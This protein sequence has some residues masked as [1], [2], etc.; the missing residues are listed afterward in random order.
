MDL[1]KLNLHE[2]KISIQPSVNEIEIAID[3]YVAHL[4]ERWEIPLVKVDEKDLVYST[5]SS[6]LGTDYCI[7][8]MLEHA[9]MHPIRHEFQ[10]RQLLK[11]SWTTSKISKTFYLFLHLIL[12][13]KSLKHNY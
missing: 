8:A 13:Q 9:V 1:Q 5:Y 7:E 3:E 2:P 11:N 12:K 4:L 10:L 6:N